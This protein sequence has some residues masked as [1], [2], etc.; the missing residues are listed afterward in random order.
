MNRAPSIDMMH[1][2]LICDAENGK[3]FWRERGP[4]M[5]SSLG[6]V[7]QRACDGWNTKFAGKEALC[8]TASSHGYKAGAI[9]NSQI[10]AH[11]VIWAMVHGY[12][13]VGVDHINGDRHDNRII[14]LREADQAHNT[15]N[16]GP[17]TG[18]SSRFIGVMRIGPKWR[19]EIRHQRRTTHL[20]CF[21]TE[22]EAA[23]ARDA[24]AVELRGEFARLNFPEEHHA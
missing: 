8:G 6:G 18:T 13:P 5:F 11:R 2:L 7:Q 3:L 16:A 1:K 10:L 24:K 19:A 12:W 15:Q 21:D 9:M 20:G 4:E 14:N 22:E 23:R 17:R